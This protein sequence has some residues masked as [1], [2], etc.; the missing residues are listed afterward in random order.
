MNAPALIHTAYLPSGEYIA[1]LFRYPEIVVETMETYRKQTIRNH[2][3]IYGPNGK[4][5]LTIPVEKPGG[6]HTLTR[7]IRVSGHEPWQ[8]THWRSIETAYNNSPFFLFYRDYFE[9]FYLK[10]FHFLLDFNQTLLNQVISIMKIPV[11]IEFTN[12]FEKSPTS[13]T[14]LRNSQ[15]TRTGAEVS[16]MPHYIQV[17]E[18]THGFI[19][20]LSILDLLF[21][22]G[23]ETG[24]YLRNYN[25]NSV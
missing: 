15:L 24:D 9:P 5:Q 11:T 22:L 12:H 3:H 10:K 21:N 18:P 8:R 25:K 13:L 6:N 16:P 19:A 2:C 23:P 4:Q 1:V 17:F 7:D 14:D 20:G